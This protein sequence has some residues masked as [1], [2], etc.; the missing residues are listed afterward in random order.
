MAGLTVV[1]GGIRSGKSRVAERLARQRGGAAVVY[2]ATDLEQGEAQP[3][4]TEELV[5]RWLP[6]D[7]VMAMVASGEIGDTSCSV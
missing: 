2:L 7:E 3:E 1:L 4:G 6:F 5:V